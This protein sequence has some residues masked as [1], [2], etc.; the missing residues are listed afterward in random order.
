MLFA[1]MRAP[2]E[3]RAITSSLYYSRASSP[4]WSRLSTVTSLQVSKTRGSTIIQA[5]LS[6]YGHMSTNRTKYVE[7]DGALR[8]GLIVIGFS[9]YWLR[10]QTRVTA[11][12]PTFGLVRC[13]K[14]HLGIKGKG[15]TST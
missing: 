7:A 11:P 10:T 12:M 14:V 15:G 5:Y 9:P 2:A 3:R 4:Y 8:S 1:A 6:L 13:T